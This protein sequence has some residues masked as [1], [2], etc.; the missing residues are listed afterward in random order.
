VQPQPLPQHPDG[1][2]ARRVDAI[3]ANQTQW[4]LRLATG[5]LDEPAPGEYH[6]RVWR[7]GSLV[8]ARTG[9][10]GVIL[11]SATD[12]PASDYDLVLSWLAATGSGD[13]LIWSAVPNDAANRALLARGATDS[14]TPHWMWKSLARPVPTVV[15]PERIELAYANERDLPELIAAGNREIPYFDEQH[16]RAMIRLAEEQGDGPRIRIILAREVTRI[17]RVRLAGLVAVNTIDHDGTCIAGLFNLGV[18][19]DAR[20]RGIGT[21]LTLAALTTA[22]QQGATAIGLNATR[23]GER[24]YRKLGFRSAGNGQTWFMPSARLRHRPDAATVAQAEALSRGDLTGLDPG[25]ARVGLLPNGDSPIAY[26]ARFDQATAARWLLAEGA[27]PDIIAL[28]KL[29]MHEEAIALMTDIRAVNR[30]A[31]QH[32]TSPLHDAVDLGDIALAKLLIAAGADLSLQ[33]GLYKATPAA[34]AHYGNHPEFAEILPY[35][36]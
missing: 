2:N 14:F 33:D 11:A 16:L 22:R 10:S 32:A 15:L 29:G 3:F 36:R 23:D 9:T 1:E 35:E 30:I 26:A 7:T 13:V 25:I 21:A 17:R 6:L 28:W 34:W 31:G 12:G 20:G 27:A 24:I 18:R 5:K 4:L 8:A 19:S